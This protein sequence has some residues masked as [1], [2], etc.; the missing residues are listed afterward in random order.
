MPI[1]HPTIRQLTD[2]VW[3]TEVLNRWNA[4][5]TIRVKLAGIGTVRFTITDEQFH[6]VAHW[7]DAGLVSEIS[8][9]VTI[10]NPYIGISG[11]ARNWQAFAGGQYSAAASI[12]TRRLSFAGPF[13]IGMKYAKGFDQL[14][15]VART[16]RDGDSQSEDCQP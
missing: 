5:A 15:L 7:D 14:A 1:T 16:V 4:D 11:T 13:Q 8:N 10:P 9:F 6:I 12:L 3:W 2:T